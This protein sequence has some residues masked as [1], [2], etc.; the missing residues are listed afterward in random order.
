M[1]VLAALAAP[2]QAASNQGFK[3]SVPAML[4]GLADNT[5]IEALISVGDTIGS[6][7]FESIPDG[8]AIDPRGTSQVDVYVNHETSLVPFPLTPIPVSDYNNAQLSRLVLKTGNGDVLSGSY[9][10][11][12]GANYQRFCSNFF[13]GSEQ[14]FDK[15][16]IFT[17][18]E[19]TD[20]VNRSGL[21]W[22]SNI[23]DASRQQAGVVVAYDPDTGAYRS[24]LGMGR[25]NHENSVV[26]PGYEQAVIL[27][28]DDTFSAPAS[29]MYM[30]LAA[31]REAVWNDQGSLW[32]FQADGAS[33][34][35]GD[36]AVG[37]KLTGRFIEVPRAIALGEQAPLEDWS[38]TNNVFQFIRI[39]DIAYDRSAPNVV[40]FAD[41]GE[42]R[43]IADAITGRLR[44]G[45]SG[46]QGLYPNGRIFKMALDP[47]DPTVVTELS[48]L[49]D[50]DALGAVSAGNINLIHN[51]DNIETTTKSLLIQ[52]DPGSQN[53]YAATN[54]NGTTA[55]IWLYDFK[56][57]ALSVVAKV[58]QSL[59]PAA[60]QGSWES[61][62]IVD[63]S[64]LF[65]QGS[66]L[67]T[68]QAHS[69][70]LDSENL[71]GTL[72][73]REHGQ[74]LILKIPGA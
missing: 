8:I 7:S 38:N 5:K 22:P 65:G 17:N 48:I 46:T 36:V 68:I 56:T 43:A 58:D 69:I 35:Y 23:G 44:R 29:Q 27:S 39:E 1:V 9:A 20:F 25:H 10:I 66:F 67:V 16:L 2:V 63:A 60:A 41:T 37:D 42:P 11:S 55:R 12:S 47:E 31:D 72:F 52:E 26:L 54:S 50:G 53:Q 14:G 32:A 45:P 24:I 51:P 70:L 57:G 19:A 62:G 34:D 13:A 59:D 74:L 3:T 40:Y 61:S 15:P 49:I 21:A 33:N 6:Y 64:D 73:K 28:G 4:V 71:G 30:Y 18:E